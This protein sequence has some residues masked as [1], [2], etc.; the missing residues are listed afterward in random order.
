[1]GACPY[2]PAPESPVGYELTARLGVERGEAF[3]EAALTYAGSLWLQGYPARSLLLVNRALGC[4]FRGDEG[5]LRRWPLP[6]AAVSWILRQP[7]AGRFLGNPRRHYQHLATRMVEPMRE[8]RTWR[9]WA[10][11]GLSSVL[12]PYDEYPADERQ[13]AREGVIEPSL[14]EIGEALERLGLPGE[15]SLWRRSFE[16]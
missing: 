6:Y 14:R 16:G 7:P 2:L 10:C 3:Y 9:A 15:A 4:P 5:V 13:I 8:L 12:L 1:M 11:W